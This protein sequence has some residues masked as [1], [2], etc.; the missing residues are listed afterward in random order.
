M[1]NLTY[2]NVNGK[3]KFIQNKPIIKV[4]NNL[5]IIRY[6]VWYRKP[7]KILKL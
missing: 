3:C 4:Y 2:F 6:G 5:V 1:R 7:K